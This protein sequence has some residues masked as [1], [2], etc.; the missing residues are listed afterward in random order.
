RK[1]KE[2]K[3]KMNLYTSNAILNNLAVFPLLAEYV[4]ET[5]HFEHLHLY[6]PNQEPSSDS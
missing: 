5:G 6:L 1:V 3:L 2:E 4:L